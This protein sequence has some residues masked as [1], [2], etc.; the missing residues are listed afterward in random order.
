MLKQIEIDTYEIE[1]RLY[2]VHAKLKVAGLAVE[3]I[4]TE[5]NNEEN[6]QIAYVISEAR[7]EINEIWNAICA[8]EVKL[9]TAVNSGPRLV[10]S[11]DSPG[12]DREPESE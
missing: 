1:N 12:E 10:F 11:A 3:A 7:N 6:V 8:A 5:R 2:A 4:D 9:G